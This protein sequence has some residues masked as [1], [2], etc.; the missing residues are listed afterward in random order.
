MSTQR[1]MEAAADYSNDSKHSTDGASQHTT[2]TEEVHVTRGV[3]RMEAL[4]A[5]AKDKSGRFTLW[6]IALCIF[7]MYW[8]YCQQSSTTY[9]YSI[10]ATSSFASHSAGISALGIATGIIGS[11]CQPFLAK[12]SDVFSRPWLCLVSLV[13][14]VIGFV[15]ILK[16]PNLA[17]YVVGNVFVSIGSTGLSLLSSILCADLVPLKYRG[18]A[19]GIL[20]APYIVIPWYS[21]EIA[22]ALSN[23]QNWRWGYGMYAIIM[24]VVMGPCIALL[25]YLEHRAQKR[26]IISAASAGQAITDAAVVAEKE[27]RQDASVAVKPT[28]TVTQRILLAWEELDGVGLIL[29][30]F[31]WSLLLL[32][33]SLQSGAKGGYSN[34]S[35][36]AM[37]AVGSICLLA[38]V[39]Y[40]FY[41]A[42]YPSFPRRLLYNRTF[43]TAIVIDFIYMCAGYMQLAYLSSYVYIVTDYDTKEFGYWSN[44]LT[45]AL[46]FGGVIAGLLQTWTRRYKLVQILGICVKIIGYGLLVD[47]NGVHDTARLV[48]SQVFT[49]LGGAMSVVGSQVSSQASVPHQDVALV[50][51]LLALWTAIGGAIGT[52]VSAGVWENHM[53]V[54]LRKFIPESVN[55]TMIE[56][57][58]GDIT[59]I[60]AYD[61]NDPIRQGAIKAYETTC[62]PLWAAALGLSFVMLI[63]A[64]FQSNYFLGD[65]QNAYDHRDTSGNIVQEEKNEHVQATG[66]RKALRFWDL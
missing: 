29:L 39:P 25:F 19:Q 1:D 8:M 64:L 3:A 24:P 27:G 12:M 18:L 48:M 42:K 14:Y 65:S 66:W 9:Q 43:M 49:G 57:F 26:G 51:A 50:I 15:M 47:K 23:D 22:N 52:A 45:V 35:L 10:W 11:V 4:A 60:K 63:A 53:P 5:A 41:L 2:S 38:Y 21:A 40:E 37:F 55:D 6:A 61:Y 7:I 59:Q 33:F 34:P 30:G 20:S 62:Y 46:C 16:S 44:T 13:A 31:G 36:I 56:T 17:T 54:N 58:F 28:M 32:P